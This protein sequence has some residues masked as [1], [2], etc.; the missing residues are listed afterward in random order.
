M[1]AVQSTAANIIGILPPHCERVIAVS[2][3]AVRTPQNQQCAGD[4][5]AC[6]G[7]DLVV[8]EIDGGGSAVVLTACADRIGVAEAAHVFRYRLFVEDRARAGLLLEFS[9]QKVLGRAADENFGQIGFLC[10]EEPVVV[11]GRQ[12][13]VHI[14]ENMSG[15]HDVEDCGPFDSLGVVEAESMGDSGA[16]VVAHNRETVVP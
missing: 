4:P 8:F 12:G 14:R 5:A 13:A 3:E 2:D 15:R 9:A 6:R 11:N 1:P 10:E 7:V 16:A